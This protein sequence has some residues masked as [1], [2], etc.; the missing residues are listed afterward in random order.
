MGISSHFIVVKIV[1]YLTSDC[2]S[3]QNP[4]HDRPEGKEPELRE[5]KERASV[6]WKDLRGWIPAVNQFGPSYRWK[7][8]VMVRRWQ[9][10]DQ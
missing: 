5:S 6:S 4:C 1:G 7:G 2:A 9:G 3:R 8:G 10:G